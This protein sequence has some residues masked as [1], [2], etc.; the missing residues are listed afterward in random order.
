MIGV[1]Q[2]VTGIQ[3]ERSRKGISLNLDG[4]LSTFE[5]ALLARHLRGCPSCRAFAAAAT[6]QT[7]LLRD[8]ALDQP[9]QRVVITAE[10]RRVRRSVAGAVG[11]AALAAAVAALMVVLPGIRHDRASQT[12]RVSVATA[13]MLVVFAARPDVTS[14]IEVPRLRVEPASAADGPV[15][16]AFSVPFV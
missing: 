13:P 8:A 6:E 5:V 15:H 3:C 10:P 12:A 1:V 7:R 9:R 14:N 4:M 16:G 11:A 2:D